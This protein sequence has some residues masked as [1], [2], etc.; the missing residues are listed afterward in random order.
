[1][2]RKLKTSTHLKT[3]V[4]RPYRCRIETL[5][6]VY[7]RAVIERQSHVRLVVGKGIIPRGLVLR[8]GFGQKQSHPAPQHYFI[9]VESTSCENSHASC[10]ESRRKFGGVKLVRKKYYIVAA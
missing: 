2:I 6:V 7:K 9:F 4:G 8:K 3:Y 1:M 10:S 5:V